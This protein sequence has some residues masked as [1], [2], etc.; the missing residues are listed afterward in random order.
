MNILLSASEVTPFAKTGGLA[1]VA[2]SLPKELQRLGHDVRI[3]MPLYR[4]VKEGD[5][6]LSLLGEL[7]PIAA[8][9]RSIAGRLWQGSLHNVP[10]YFLEQDGFFD[11]DGLYGTSKNDYPDN[12]ER[13]G[14]FARAMLSALPQIGFQP[15]VLHLNDWQTGLV[16]A[17]LR[18][19]WADHPFYA[20]TATLITIHNL[21][22]QGLFPAQTVASL[23]L[24]P[25]LFTMEGLEYYGQVSFLKSGLVY[26]DL[27]TTVSETYCTEIQTPP[28]GH[29]FDGILRARA[30]RLFGV[31]N[32]IDEQLWDPR[33]DPA[34]PAPYHAGDLHGKQANKRHLQS[35]LGL[36]S[37]AGAPLVAMVTR[38]AGQKGLDLVE[39]AWEALLERGVQVAILGAGDQD[40]MDRFA[41]L[42][43]QSP[44]QAAVHLGFDDRLARMLYAG[45][46]MFL[47]P[48]HYEP[49]GLGQLIALRYGSVPVVRKTGGLA[50]TV[51]DPRDGAER[52][53]G[54]IFEEISAPALL[55]AID[56]ALSHFRDSA[57]WLR[58][59]RNGMQGDFSWRRSALRYVELYRK[60]VELHHV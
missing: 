57:E 44:G 39:E 42:G 14:Y 35:E 1:D 56:R 18:T 11:R 2:G 53:N 49:C 47:M 9:G 28:M 24:D 6:R 33:H 17:L 46:D 51:F 8:G 25:G 13:F 52:A 41:K 22:Y 23:G 59:V 29:G 34:L 60:A 16:P 3:F 55:E 15:E 37:D 50:D 30:H 26:A 40:F 32:G 12:A 10:V 38:L 19:E 5:F 21:G 45:S 7:A 4:C 58:L 48:S 43:A 31:L 27:I 36:E 54:F 20:G